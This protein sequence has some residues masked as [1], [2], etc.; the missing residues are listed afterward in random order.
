MTFPW[1]PFITVTMGDTEYQEGKSQEKEAEKLRDPAEEKKNDT[2]TPGKLCPACGAQNPPEAKFCGECGTSLEGG[3]TCPRCGTEVPPE[4]DVCEVCGTWLLGALCKFCYTPLPDQASFCPECGNPREGITCPSCG[5]LSYFDFC[6]SCH[7]PLSEAAGEMREDLRSMPGGEEYLSA[8]EEA[9]EIRRE[10]EALEG[11]YPEASPGERV[12]EKPRAEEADQKE[13]ADP[14]E[15]SNQEEAEILA[16]LRALEER[17]KAKKGTPSS[18]RRKDKTEDS[19]QPRGFT[20]DRPSEGR[21]TQQEKLEEKRKR[22]RELKKRLERVTPKLK[23]PPPLDFSTA[24][25]QEIR[26]YFMAV[27]PP[28]VKGWLCNAFNALHEDP[29]HCVNPAGGGRW[30]LEED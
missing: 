29:M 9:E 28:N 23:H 17:V 21:R 19:L 24:K 26:R 6:P 11:H 20:G 27:K 2:G 3:K 16:N 7:T 10:I 14:E 30:I 18:A 4:G 1:T 25:N 15:A 13:A 12:T 5:T 22:L 8:L